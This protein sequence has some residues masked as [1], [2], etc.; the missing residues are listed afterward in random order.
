LQVLEQFDDLAIRSV[1][2]LRAAGTAAEDEQQPTRSLHFLTE[3]FLVFFI[4]L[5]LSTVAGSVQGMMA[6]TQVPKHQL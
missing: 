1:F 4:F 3:R 2:E 5:K 6:V